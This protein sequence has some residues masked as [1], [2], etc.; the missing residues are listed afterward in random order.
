MVKGT[1]WKFSKK[2]TS[3]LG[4]E[5]LNEIAKIFGGFGKVFCFFFFFFRNR[6]I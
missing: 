4:G 1:F 3:H 6:H 5:K 2:N